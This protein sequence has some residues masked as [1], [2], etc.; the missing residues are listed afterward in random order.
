MDQPPE[1]KEMDSTASKSDNVDEELS[2]LLDSSLQD[3]GKAT[4]DHSA[5]A[6]VEVTPDALGASPSFDK[7]AAQRAAVEFQS[8]LRQLSEMQ[9]V[10]VDQ[11]QVA[12][13]EQLS[14]VVAEG[15]D[16]AALA[17]AAA[18]LTAGG[19]DEAQFAQAFLQNLNFLAEKAQKIQ[20][21]GSEDELETAIRQ[22]Q[23][24]TEY[25]NEFLPFM[26]GLMSSLLSKDTLY[27]SLK[28]MSEKYPPWLTENRDKT[29]PATLERYEAQLRLIQE[30]CKEFEEEK[31][32]D[33]DDVKGQRFERL[34]IVMQKM[35]ACGHPPEDLVGSLPAGWAMDEQTGIPQV[36]DQEKAAEACSIM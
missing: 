13:A 3:F 1:K 35:Q 9:K 19:P 8:M 27:P 23:S 10:M 20:E 22:L 11:M 15:G 25:E 28:E 14:G 32:D 18:G 34:I 31:E 29:D 2:K 17:T 16:A 12:G 26:Q 30:A 21:A 6:N 33:P 24:D 4:P 5:S 7:D 36:V